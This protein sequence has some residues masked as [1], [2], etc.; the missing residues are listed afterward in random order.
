MVSIE[1]SSWENFIKMFNDNNNVSLL[2]PI[3]TDVDFYLG[4]DEYIIM[5]LGCDYGIVDVDF[6][7]GSDNDSIESSYENY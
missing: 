3:S 6:D 2:H 1:K 4:L 5:S 7:L